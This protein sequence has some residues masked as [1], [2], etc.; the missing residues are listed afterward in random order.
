MEKENQPTEKSLFKEFS[1]RNIILLM[2]IM[3]AFFVAYKYI[4]ANIQENKEK[5]VIQERARVQQQQ[6]I[7]KEALIQEKEKKQQLDSCLDQAKQKKN[8]A[9]TSF[10]KSAQETCRNSRSCVQYA[11]DIIEE[12]KAE[13][14]IDRDDCY[15]RYK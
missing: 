3:F 11:L 13:E 10:G 8:E 2:L 12:F 14:K 4:S 6:E 15:K 7:K 1:P 9:I 5:A